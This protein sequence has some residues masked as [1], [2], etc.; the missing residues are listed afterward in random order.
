MIS[1]RRTIWR[2]GLGNSSAMH[3]LPGTVSTMR[4]ETS[5]SARDRSFARLTTWLPL[6]PVAGSIS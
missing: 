5:D 1:D 3:D 2:L 6:T 4:T